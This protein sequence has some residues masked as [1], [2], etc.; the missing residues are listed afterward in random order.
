MSVVNSTE[1][2]ILKKDGRVATVVFNRPE[3]LNAM[4]EET[5]K[6][7]SVKLDD[8]AA[9]SE[10]DV[11]VLCG[12]GKGFSAG[13]DIKSMLSNTDESM[14]GPVMDSISEL[15]LKLYTLPKIVI[16]AIHGPAAGI[17]FSLALASDYVW[18]HDS[19]VLAM[20]FIGISLIPDGGGHFFLEKRIGEV[21]AKQLIWEGKKL[22][23][24]EA[25]DLG[26]VD[27]VLTGDFQSTINERVHA[28]LNKP[29]KAMIQTKKVFNAVNIEKLKTVLEQ[30]K[31][32]QA[33]MRKSLDHK[34]GV[35]AFLEKRIPKFTGK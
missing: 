23:A 28:I 29:V 33:E 30:E 14:F 21:K 32:G 34:E 1:H 17:G 18:A 5:F 13:G 31:I 2:V 7:F 24:E 26:L 15:V 27:D 9:S 10:I 35:Q 20:N 22:T 25:K 6:E 3:V 19:A 12:N 16:S 4:N 8:I 11:V